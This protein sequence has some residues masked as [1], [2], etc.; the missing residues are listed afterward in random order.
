MKASEINFDLS[1]TVEDPIQCTV[2]GQPNVFGKL[3]ESCKAKLAE[4][5]SADVTVRRGYLIL[6]LR[7]AAQEFQ[8]DD[9]G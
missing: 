8:E 9:H 7:S 1:V 6:G 3:C 2:C 4:L 5:E